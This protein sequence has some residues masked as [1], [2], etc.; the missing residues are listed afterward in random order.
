MKV[1]H[2][3]HCEALVFFENVR[4][5]NCDHSLAYLPDL[6]VIGSL[7][8]AGENLWTSPLPRAAGR[9]YRLCENYVKHNVCNWAVPADDPN[10]LCLSCRLTRVIPDLGKPG[11]KGTW[12]KLDAGTRLLSQRPVR[13]ARP[14]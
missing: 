7:T 4:C 14:L 2:C 13:R 11:N 10:P 9:Q 8:Q 12:Y 1:F 6:Q 5:V 3:D